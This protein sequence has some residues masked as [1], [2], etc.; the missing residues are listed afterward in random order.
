MA[1]AADFDDIH[2]YR[3]GLGDGVVR[4]HVRV[5]CYQYAIQWLLVEEHRVVRTE[6]VSIQLARLPSDF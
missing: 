3:L 6:T 4:Y 5:R 2:G 1:V